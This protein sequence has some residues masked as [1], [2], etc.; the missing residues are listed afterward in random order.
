[1]KTLPITDTSARHESFFARVAHW[2]RRE[3][4]PFSEF[5]VLRRGLAPQPVRRVDRWFPPRQ[6]LIR[7]AGRTSVVSFAPGL[8]IAVVAMGVFGFVGVVATIVA[9]AWGHRTAD[10]M[11]HEMEHLRSTARL[12]TQRAAE[13]REF[14]RR[15]GLDLSRCFA[16]RDRA[17]SAAYAGG[18][19][20]AEQ[21]ITIARLIAEREVSIDHARAEREAVVEQASAEREA[22]VEHAVAQRKTAVENAVAERSRIAVERDKALSERDKALS[23]R[24]AALTANREVLRHLDAQTQSTIAQV[25]GIISATGLDLARV[26]N[27][28]PAPP[29]DERTGPRGGPF[30]PWKQQVVADN[31]VEARR[32]HGV[33]SSLERLKAL[34]DT[35]ARVPLATPLAQLEISNGFG[36]RVDPFTGLAAMHEGLDLRGNRNTEIHATA[37]GTVAFAG[38]KSDY[39]NLVEINHGSGLVSRYAHLSSILVKTGD[40]VTLHQKL[41]LIGATGRAT[42]AH[43]HYEIRVD[44]QARNPVNFLK[45]HRNVSE[46]ATTPSSQFSGFNHH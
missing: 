46:K 6:F 4:Q 33:A 16:E 27:K 37:A 23:E 26:V 43:L 24:D 7:T 22:A 18:K 25:E 20:M 29:T 38:W 39:G 17:A 8:Q 31:P 34:R 35:L 2:G 41:G 28:A 3:K 42:G 14:V 15:L 32:I 45:A 10:Q 21:R 11:A 40:P 1:M 44:G 30:V 36:F 9:A 5:D 19:T 12:E 13:D